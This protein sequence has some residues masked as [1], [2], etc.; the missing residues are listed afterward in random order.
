MTRQ[1]FVSTRL[2]TAK[3]PRALAVMQM[4]TRRNTEMA[5]WNIDTPVT[6]SSVG[7]M[8]PFGGFRSVEGNG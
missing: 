5:S 2:S 1:A 8:I 6:P 4:D 7:A 3:T